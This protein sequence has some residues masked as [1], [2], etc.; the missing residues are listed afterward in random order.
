M[1]LFSR[2]E[3]WELEGATSSPWRREHQSRSRSPKQDASG[4]LPPAV[5]WHAPNQGRADGRA[6]LGV[7]HGQQPLVHSVSVESQV[8]GE[9]VRGNGPKAFLH[10]ANQALGEGRTQK[11]DHFDGSGRAIL[12]LQPESGRRELTTRDAKKH[13][14]EGFMDLVGMSPARDIGKSESLALT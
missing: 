9:C 7:E 12:F 6:E 1:L 3:A 13:A 11:F 8:A 5:V 4:G 14:D 2:G 10:V